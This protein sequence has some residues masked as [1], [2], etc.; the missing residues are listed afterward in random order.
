M[1]P[2]QLDGSFKSRSSQLPL[3]SRR[4]PLLSSGTNPPAPTCLPPR[5]PLPAARFA[6]AR[7]AGVRLCKT[8]QKVT[9]ILYQPTRISKQN[10]VCL[11]PIDAELNN[12]RSPNIENGFYRNSQSP[13]GNEVWG[14][15][16]KNPL[17]ITKAEN[18]WARGLRGWGRLERRRSGGALHHWSTCHCRFVS[19]QRLGNRRNRSPTSPFPDKSPP[20]EGPRTTV[21]D[22]I[23][24]K[25]AFREAG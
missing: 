4:R 25:I 3:H 6:T 8:N 15:G 20:R 18:K 22:V 9:E 17:A 14:C 13:G 19:S 1:W 7:V 23:T 21:L 24:M 2:R 10:Q 12:L 11:D 16:A 5:V